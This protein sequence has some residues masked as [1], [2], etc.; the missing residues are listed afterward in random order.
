MDPLDARLSAAGRYVR[1]DAELASAFRA[2]GEARAEDARRR[3]RRRLAAPVLTLGAVLGLTGAGGVAATQWG[4][5]H[6][7][8]PDI[9]IARQWTDVAGAYLGTCESRIR[10]SELPEEKRAK[11]REYFDTV[12]LDAIQ[13]N[14]EFVALHLKM[15]GRLGDIGRLVP[16]AE[17]DDFGT[18]DGETSRYQPSDAQV[19]QGALAQTIAHELFLQVGSIELSSAIETQCSD[20]P[21][22]GRS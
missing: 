20:D 18:D 2:L 11:V 19:M 10:A 7:A 6:T 4:P 5:W 14:P 1:D 12:E 15:A 9:V 21:A 8:D 17:P 22:E 16:G 13:P 3:R